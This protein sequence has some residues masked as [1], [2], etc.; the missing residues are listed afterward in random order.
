VIRPFQ[1]GDIFLI[2]RLSRQATKLNTIQALLQSHSALKAALTAV[3]PWNE[4]KAT[5]YVLH[6]RGHELART[7]FLQAQKRPGRPEADIILLAPALDTPWGHPAVWQKL[8]VYYCN[9]AA[10]QQIARIYVDA[11]D[12]PLLV[13]T[14]NQVGFRV[15]TRQTIWRLRPGQDGVLAPGGTDTTRSIRQTGVRLQT[16]TDEW[17]LQRLYAR[18]VPNQV[19]QA[20]GLQLDST[21]YG[22]VKPP[23]LEWWQT[24]ARE[25]YVFEQKGDIQGCMRL[26]YGRRGVWLQLWM[27]SHQPDTECIHQ[28]LG[29]ALINIRQEKIHLPV[30]IGVRDYQGG[31]G[32]ILAEY[33]FAPFTDR[34]KMVKHVVQWVRSVTS[35][36]APALET[37]HEV[38]PTPF[39]LPEETTPLNDAGQSQHRL[40]SP[41]EWQRSKEKSEPMFKEH[42]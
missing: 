42:C 22:A 17:A 21:L 8:L 31:L 19:K 7:G 27:D 20:E 13:N 28:L 18:V 16:K 2:Q 35:I 4:A 10:H 14:L 12:Q 36:L 9:E 1:V 29:Y 33:G 40:L 3:I 26:A 23:I 32:P 37:V 24:S 39:T 6:Q 11:P 5:T 41:A 30:Y 34:A 38:V 15:Y 25:S